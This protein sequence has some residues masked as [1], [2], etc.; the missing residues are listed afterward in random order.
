[1]V[2]IKHCSSSSIPTGSKVV[3]VNRRGNHCSTNMPNMY[4]IS[5][6]SLSVQD[7][8]EKVMSMTGA[9]STFSI[10]T[11]S[12]DSDSRSSPMSPIC[13]NT[14]TVSESEV[15]AG[16]RLELRPM[17]VEEQKKTRRWSTHT[18][19]NCTTKVKEANHTEY[20]TISIIRKRPRHTIHTFTPSPALMCNPHAPQDNWKHGGGGT[21]N[22][23]IITSNNNNNNNINNNI[24][25]NNNNEFFSDKQP[26]Q[27]QYIRK[28]VRWSNVIQMKDVK[29][30]IDP[31]PGNVL[32][33]EKKKLSISE[34]AGNRLYLKGIE[35]EKR[36]A[37]LRSNYHFKYKKDEYYKVHAPHQPSNFSV[38]TC[39]RLYNLSRPM[40]V[41]GKKR[42][43]SIVNER[44]K[45]KDLWVHPTGKISTSDATRLYHD[46]MR[47][48]ITLERR[49]INA[50]HSK[51]YKSYLIH[52][53][54][55]ANKHTS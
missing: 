55:K 47:Q 18:A 54:D 42:R 34:I 53:L 17:A 14:N 11:S 28:T 44:K 35:R 20:G 12:S 26:N 1:M 40:Q 3:N 38:D 41:Q 21:H 25:N 33:T 15:A 43:E 30:K 19:Q 16:G 7:S 8:P 51:V 5:N 10:E 6:L 48:I 2:D 49:R 9:S 31:D 13:P 50:S 46:G 4:K 37:L 27:K 32:G 52:K 24:N 23:T 29:F 22:H 45:G 36:L 39:Q